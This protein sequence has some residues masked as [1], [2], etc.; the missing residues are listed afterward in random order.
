MA[1]TYLLKPGTETLERWQLAAKEQDYGSFAEFVRDAV[2]E[3]I[4]GPRAS[5]D[6]E[7]QAAI[8]HPRA[9]DDLAGGKRTYAPDPKDGGGGKRKS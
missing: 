5:G 8:V 1:G 4:A 9:L 2:E 7:R 3:K 6:A